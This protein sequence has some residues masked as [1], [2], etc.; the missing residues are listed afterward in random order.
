MLLEFGWARARGVKKPQ[1]L[2]WLGLVWD[3]LDQL[4]PDP[5]PIVRKQ[6]LSRHKATSSG[7]NGCAVCDRD[8][9][10]PVCPAADVGRMCANSFR[11]RRLAA[12]FLREVGFDV[13]R[14]PV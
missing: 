12:A 14:A 11:Q 2:L 1:G 4:G 8:R 7:L 13:H 6:F 10:G 5:L 9:T 3:V